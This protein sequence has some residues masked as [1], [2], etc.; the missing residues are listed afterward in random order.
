MAK[1]LDGNLIKKAHAPQR[2][3]LEEVK[4]LE[5][6]MDPVTGPLY[7]AKNFL[8]I[9]HPTRGSIPFEPYDYQEKLI[10]AYHENKQCIAMLPRQMGK[11]TCA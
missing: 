1:S 8:K 7:F 5:A 6:C 9:Q 10:Q 11:T 3:T 4:H 2:Y